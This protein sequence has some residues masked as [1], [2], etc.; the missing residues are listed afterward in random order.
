MNIKFD[1]QRQVSLRLKKTKARAK[2]DIGIEQLYH[3]IKVGYAIG[4]GKL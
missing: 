3:V 2:R 4:S 1:S